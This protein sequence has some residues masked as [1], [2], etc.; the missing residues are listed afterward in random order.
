LKVV[1]KVF[2]VR[3]GAERLGSG[4]GFP[5]PSKRLEETPTIDAMEQQMEAAMDASQGAKF[6]DKSR[7]M[8]KSWYPGKYLRQ[9]SR[10]ISTG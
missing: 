1:K 2:G 7:A 3:W 8:A 9:A 10:G 4:T 5:E 6:S